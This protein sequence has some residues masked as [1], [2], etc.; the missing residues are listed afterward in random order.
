V[1]SPR[2]DNEARLL[3]IWEDTLR[4]RPLGVT[5]NFF[6][7]G[8]NSLLAVRLIA[9]IRRTTGHSLP[10]SSLFSAGTVE[11]MARLMGENSDDSAGQSSIVV[12]IQPL[13]TRRPFFCVHAGG[14]TTLGYRDLARNL[15]PEQPFYGMQS[16]GLDGVQA[17]LSTLTDMARSYVECMRQVQ[18]EGPYLIGGWCMGGII[19]FEMTRVLRAQGQRTD[20]L[21]L[22]DSESP[23]TAAASLRADAGDTAASSESDDVGLLRRFAWHFGIDL[24]QSDL[25]ELTDEQRLKHLLDLAQRHDVLP[26]DAE[27]EQLGWMLRVYKNNIHAVNAYL[28][29]FTPGAPPDHPVVL[30]R[31]VRELDAGQDAAFGWSALADTR[32]SVH[33]VPGDHHTVMRPPAVAVLAE[34]LGALLDTFREGQEA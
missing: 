31:P 27:P 28:R 26:A 6:D 21:V 3:A 15:G 14:G 1:I 24:A 9:Q 29:E 20:L 12:P 5:D 22:I 30:Y 16:L 25:A 10:L 11:S 18:P 32:L 7:V 19:A 34:R 23:T 8:G 33:L 17:P 13:G 2:D 4:T